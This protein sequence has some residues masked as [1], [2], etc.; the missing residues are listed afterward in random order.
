MNPKRNC[1]TCQH[2]DN[3]T[4]GTTRCTW[5]F[6]IMGRAGIYFGKLPPHIGQQVPIVDPT[7][8]NVCDVYVRKEL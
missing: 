3:S 2:A 7:V 4:T 8:A 6:D 1:K 5:L